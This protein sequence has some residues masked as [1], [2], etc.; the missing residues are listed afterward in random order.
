MDQHEM[1]HRRVT[2]VR[3]LTVEI[4]SLLGYMM[5]AWRRYAD[6]KNMVDES[7]SVARAPLG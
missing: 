3:P 1:T 6:S 2:Q 7:A 4:G 5:C